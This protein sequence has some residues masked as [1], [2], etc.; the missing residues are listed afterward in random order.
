MKMITDSRS[1][2]YTEKVKSQ[3]CFGDFQSL[4]NNIVFVAKCSLWEIVKLISLCD[5]VEKSNRETYLI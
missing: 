4:I 5:D 3:N 1:R 2:K